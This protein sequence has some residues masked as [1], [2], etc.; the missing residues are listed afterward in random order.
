VK[1]RSQ[2]ARGLIGASI[3]VFTAG[4]VALLAIPWLQ[5]AGLIADTPMWLLATLL[6]ACSAA[7]AGVQAIEGRLAP[8]VGLELRTATAAISSAWVV[9]ATG[10]G[11]LLVIA[12]G[13]GI[14]D[15]M[16]VHGS[17]GW[18]PGLAWSAVAIAGG[19]GAIALGWAPSV[20]PASTAHAV[21]GTT[22]LCLA[23][24]ARTLGSSTLAAEQAT[25]QIERD[26]SYFRDLVQH[27]ADVIALVSP[28]FQIDYISPGIEPLVGRAPATCLGLHIRDVLGSEAADDIARAYDTLSLS[29]Y[30]ACE[31]HLT[32]DFAEQRRGYARLT[33]RHDGWLVL[34]LRDVTEQRALEAQ[35]EHRASVDAL[36]GLPNRAALMQYLAQLETV[37]DVSVLFIDLDGF[38]EVNDALGHESGD[39]VLRD[40]AHRIASS[41]P[42]GVYVSRLG[43]DE[44]LAVMADGAASSARAAAE[45]FIA[46]IEDLGATLTRFPLSASVGIA[47][48]FGPESAEQLLHRADQAMY[49]AKAAGPGRCEFSRTPEPA[50][51]VGPSRGGFAGPIPVM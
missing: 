45:A 42:E 33:R 46:G 7:N 10:W 12:Y 25:A 16:R 18:K 24:I 34:N 38:K 5:R 29:D 41:A 17:R 9:Y 11:S 31:W 19:E 1:S 32:N 6:V 28:N 39:G 3:L 14:A 36:T 26:R 8:M 23:L 27:A 15:L 30:V 50:P 13:I 2:R 22:F 21:A 51:Q 49:R 40:V 43:G 4:P 48:G 44:F 20:L 35:L 47:T 37:V